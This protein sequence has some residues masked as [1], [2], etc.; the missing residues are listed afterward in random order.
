MTKKQH[1]K[2]LCPLNGLR[3]FV[4]WNMWLLLL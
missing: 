2:A 1:K 4:S 3:L